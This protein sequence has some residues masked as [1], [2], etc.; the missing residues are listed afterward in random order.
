MKLP[1]ENTEET[2]IIVTEKPSFIEKWRERIP[3]VTDEKQKR[4][5]KNIVVFF[6]IMLILTIVSRG[7]SGATYA[8]V[9]T[10]TP[11][12]GEIIDVVK[13]NA[14]VQSSEIN[15]VKLEA[16]FK[17]S[18]LF[19]SSGQSV[20]AG[21]DI[22]RYD[23]ETISNEVK[24]LEGDLAA[25]EID[26]AEKK[27]PKAELE[28]QT[29]SAQKTLDSAIEEYNSTK[30]SGENKIAQAQQELNNANASLEVAKNQLAE[31]QNHVPEPGEM[32]IDIELFEQAVTQA[33]G[34]VETAKSLLESE[35][36]QLSD[37]LKGLDKQI[38]DARES[39]EKAKKDDQQTKNQAEID[40][41]RKKLEL[42]TLEKEITEMQEKIAKFKAMIESTGVVKATQDGEIKKLPEEGETTQEGAVYTI[43]NPQ[44]SFEAQVMLSKDDAKKLKAGSKVDIEKGSGYYKDYFQ[45][46][47]TAISLPDEN[48]QVTVKIKLPQ[49]KWES[50]ENISIQ[51]IQKRETYET[52]IPL[53]ALNSNQDG[54]FVLAIEE[55]STILGTENV[56]VEY[57]VTLLAKDEEKAAIEGGIWQ[58]PVVTQSTKPIT[59]GDRVRV[60]ES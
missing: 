37:S 16:G 4:A 48:E 22:L 58:T 10:Q 7:M 56:L 47:I 15:E 23:L 9:K 46:E 3:K 29:K 28:T 41:R 35:K 13:G 24:K 6:A 19:V 36:T 59:S 45:G 55:R 11:T 25:K 43:T 39:L 34:E 42:E 21:D 53:S 31:A 38:T 52:C 49:G 5:G 57:P 18:K 14:T 60:M 20:K 27:L 44:G 54:Y 50:G 26:L 1:I 40:D 32:P 51:A 2:T 17:V 8:Q 12:K 30:S 33:D